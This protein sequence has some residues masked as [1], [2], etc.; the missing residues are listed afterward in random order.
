MSAVAGG[1]E[2]VDPIQVLFTLYHNMNALD[3]VGPLEAFA[4][5]QHNLKDDSTK[6]FDITFVGAEEHTLAA[7]G[8][9]FRAHIGL[10][11]AYKRLNEF[12]MLVVPGGGTEE[13]MKNQSE[14]L[15]LIRSFAD[16]AE[17]D[18]TR[19]RT[20]FSVDTGS[21]L[22]ASQG[23]LQGLAATTHPDHYIKLEL[24]CQESSQKGLDARTDIMEDERYVVNNGRFDLGE[25]LDDNPYVYRKKGKITETAARKGSIAR[26]ESNAKRENIIRRSEMRVGGCRVV[27]ASGSTSGLDAALYLVSAL[28]SHDSAQEVSRLLQ[29]NWIK[30]VV[31]DAIDV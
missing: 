15:G 14:P 3:F 7:Q 31:V 25:N 19:E 18:P 20:I 2:S 12:D 9:S 23:I 22:L 28:V 17:S 11:E 16:Q 27:T 13:I 30:G 29:Y 1:A 6:A 21:L 10:K 4:R 5:A 26:K 24:L 8:A